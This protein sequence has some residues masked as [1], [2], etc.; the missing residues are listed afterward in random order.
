MEN[1]VQ[2]RSRN[3]G[4]RV[5]RAE[6][7]QRVCAEFCNPNFPETRVLFPE[8]C[9]CVCVCIVGSTYRER[10]RGTWQEEKRREDKREEVDKKIKDED[11][12]REE[13]KQTRQEKKKKKKKARRQEEKKEEKNSA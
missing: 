7:K 4:L 9:V 8:V 5:R 6:S 13:E 10:K 11:R 3:R 12:S 2:A 1:Q